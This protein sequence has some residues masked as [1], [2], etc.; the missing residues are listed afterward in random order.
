M[1]LL[2]CH[3]ENRKSRETLNL[4]IYLTHRFPFSARSCVSTY[5]YTVVSLDQG[6]PSLESMTSLVHMH[7]FC[8]MTKLSA[9]A[10]LLTSMRL[11]GPLW[12]WS[13]LLPLKRLL[14]GSP[15]RFVLMCLTV[16]AQFSLYSPQQNLRQMITPSLKQFHHLTSRSPHTPQLPLFSL[17]L[18]ILFC[19]L[20][21]PL[22][23]LNIGGLPISVPGLFLFSAFTH[24]ATAS[25]SGAITTNG[26][27]RPPCP[28]FSG[29]DCI[30]E[31]QT[32]YLTSLH[33]WLNTYFKS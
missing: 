13:L 7:L 18:L 28:D 25:K 20:F 8:Y 1:A 27:P 14:S 9:Y 19:W 23:P 32:L 24:S 12:P 33:R 17:L 2:L 11:L 4:W 22:W 16:S 5:K 15:R 10:Q 31:L 21:F 30:T 29:P 3:W 6:G 26:P